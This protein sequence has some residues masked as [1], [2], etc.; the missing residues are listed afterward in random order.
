[1]AAATTAQTR[2]GSLLQNGVSVLPDVEM[3]CGKDGADTCLGRPFEC[4]FALVFTH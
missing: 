4:F 1:M 2:A 3:G